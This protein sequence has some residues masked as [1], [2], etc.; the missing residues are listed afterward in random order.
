MKTQQNRVKQ[1]EQ[2]VPPFERKFY[3][4]KGN[5]WTP[6][7]EAEAIR[8]NPTKQFFYRSLLETP[9]DTPRK[10]ADPTAEL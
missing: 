4:W 9:E 8:R 10:M 6:E 5:P 2:Q 1:L 3:C 7:Q